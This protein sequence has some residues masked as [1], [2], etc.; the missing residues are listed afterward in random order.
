MAAKTARDRQLHYQRFDPA[1]ADAPSMGAVS[2]DVKAPEIEQATETGDTPQWK[3]L[4]VIK[5]NERER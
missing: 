2:E 4:P 3:Y 5:D 1:R